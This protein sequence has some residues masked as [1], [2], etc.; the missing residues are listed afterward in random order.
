[1]SLPELDLKKDE[2]SKLILSVA[3]VL[4]HSYYHA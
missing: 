1:M 2:K 4:Y 3:Q